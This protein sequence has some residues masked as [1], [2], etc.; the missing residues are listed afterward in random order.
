MCLIKLQVNDKSLD[1]KSL[2]E[3]ACLL[4]EAPSGP[5]KI[6]LSRAA[7][8]CTSTPTTSSSINTADS[9]PDPVA[10]DN[11]PTEPN[12]SWI[13]KGAKLQVLDLIDGRFYMAVAQI[14]TATEVLLKY[15][16]VRGG[17][18]ETKSLGNDCKS[19]CVYKYV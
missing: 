18:S 11:T 7:S 12:K 1:G 13:S 2:E 10:S 14:V 19:L 17:W 6:L 8:S 15:P 16:N 9:E 5:V 3:A 4:K